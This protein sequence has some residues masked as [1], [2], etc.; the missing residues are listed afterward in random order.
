MKK[1]IDF[2]TSSST[3]GNM[4]VQYTDG[5]LNLKPDYQREYVWSDEFKFKLVYSLVR[6]YPIGN[7]TVRKLSADEKGQVNSEVVDG[8]QRLTTIFDFLEGRLLI[9]GEDAFNIF[10]EVHNLYTEKERGSKDVS[11]LIKKFKSK[12]KM[13]FGYSLLPNRSQIQI[14]NYNLS[15]STINQANNTEVAEYFRFVQNQERL[16]AGEILNAFIDSEIDD[17]LYENCDVD[18]VT[19]VLSFDNSRKD[20]NKLF[21]AV[22]GLVLGEI[23]F[24]CK[25]S[26]IISFVRKITDNGLSEE[27]KSI[28][29]RLSSGLNKLSD[30]DADLVKSN[31]RLVKLLMLLIGFDF[32]DLSAYPIDKIKSLER[33]NNN[34]SAFNSAKANEVERV[35]GTKFTTE[36]IE[37]HRLVALITKGGHNKKRVFERVKIMKNIL[38][39]E[40]Y[41]K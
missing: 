31:K 23:N 12:K 19:S 8:Q 20:F 28:V 2:T 7:I 24:G 17:M 21:S 22:V 35:F 32:L 14:N 33:F 3:V 18:K 5:N 29:K 10:D 41:S 11:N 26:D 15:I 25:D 40:Y 27:V 39:Q 37:D 6:N 38:E 13:I 16:R 34:L 36:S 9:K 4:W 30:F 1:R